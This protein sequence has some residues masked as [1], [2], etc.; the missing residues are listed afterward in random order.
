M[1]ANKLK[2]GTR[3]LRQAFI[4][5]RSSYLDWLLSPRMLIVPV[6]WIFFYELCIRSMIEHSELMNTPLNLLE[7][8]ILI[9]NS[10]SAVPLIPIFYL[11][12]VSD[13]PRMG[14]G[15]LFILARTGKAPWLFGQVLFFIY[16]ALSYISSLF[17]VCFLM[18][19]KNAYLA[20]GWSEV[21]RYIRNR[22]DFDALAVAN[23]ASLLPQN[24]YMHSRPY[25]ACAR[26]ILLMLLYLLVI[27]GIML[28]FNICKKKT[29]GIIVAIV[30]VVMGLISWAELG[31]VMWFFPMANSIFGWHNQGLY[32]EM[33]Y[34]LANSYIYF[35]VV[36]TLLFVISYFAIKRSPI[37]ASCN[38]S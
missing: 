35:A 25:A 4:A 14:S 26:S 21:T 19:V 20:D 13:C 5:G 3:F 30:V 33:V 38:E 23:Q 29:V 36:L 1:A 28:L 24:L 27:G 34:P 8:F 15:E 10:S 12:L 22:E 32:A 18:V 37:H 6:T 2:D 7:P 16:S 9:T 17:V 31:D 11:M